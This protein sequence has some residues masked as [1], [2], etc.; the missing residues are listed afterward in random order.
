MSTIFETISVG[1]DKRMKDEGL[2]NQEA[3][4]GYES[5]L[6]DPVQQLFNT[7]STA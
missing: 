6:Y 3:I 5:Y 4:S 1:I 7:W 2:I